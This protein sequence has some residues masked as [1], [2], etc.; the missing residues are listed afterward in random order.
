MKHI[1]GFEKFNEGVGSRIVAKTVGIAATSIGAIKNLL[2]L[3]FKEVYKILQFTPHIMKF[4]D[5]TDLIKNQEENINYERYVLDN[6]PDDYQIPFPQIYE[7]PSEQ[8]YERESMKREYKNRFNRDIIRDLSAIE[9]F[10]NK[11]IAEEMNK[12]LTPKEQTGM[13][14]I[15]ELIDG[16]KSIFIPR[17]NMQTKTVAELRNTPRRS[18]FQQRLNDYQREYGVNLGNEDEERDPL[19]NE[20]PRY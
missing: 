14:K 13:D 5:I 7:S 9:A 11:C 1:K 20:I 10:I 18:R 3:K 2:K 19:E 8:D 17:V 6:F 16:F 12:E 4:V 15:F